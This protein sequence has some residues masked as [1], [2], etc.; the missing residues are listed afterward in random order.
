MKASQE[1][2]TLQYSDTKYVGKY[3]GKKHNLGYTKITLNK[4]FEKEK[5]KI[6]SSTPKNIIIIIIIKTLPRRN[7]R[8]FPGKSSI[9]K[10]NVQQAN[11]EPISAD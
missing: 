5:G 10:P 4:E 3:R 7:L 11:L 1:I 2:R 9:V 6:F 8:N